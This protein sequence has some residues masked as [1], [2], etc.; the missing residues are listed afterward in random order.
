ML[1][2]SAA[3]SMSLFS[4]PLN[5]VVLVLIS[6]Y[7]LG[8][9]SLLNMSPLFI[10]AMKSTKPLLT[11]IILAALVFIT[12]ALSETGTWYHHRP[13]ICSTN[14]MTWSPNLISK[15]LSWSAVNSLAIIPTALTVSSDIRDC[16]FMLQNPPKLA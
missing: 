6:L 4:N 16:P 15:T 13:N 1:D 12:R 8:S 3:A 14:V 9:R 7:V 2:T 10:S 5:L 11:S